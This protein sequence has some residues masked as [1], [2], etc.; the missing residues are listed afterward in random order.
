MAQQVHVIDGIS[1]AHHPR[2]QRE[3]FACSVRTLVARHGDMLA[4][5]AR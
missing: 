4:S 3:E 2:N 1:A 5:Q